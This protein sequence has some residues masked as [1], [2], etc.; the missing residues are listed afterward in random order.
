MSP[1]PHEQRGERRGIAQALWHSGKAN[2]DVS[3]VYSL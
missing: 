3:P 1:C 2:G